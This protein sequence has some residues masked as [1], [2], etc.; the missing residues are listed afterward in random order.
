MD[1]AAT[2]DF[3]RAR[4]QA[5]GS[6]GLDVFMEAANACYYAGGES[7]G[8]AGDFITAPEISQ[9]FGE[10]IG[11]WTAVIWQSLGSPASF[12]LVELG[13]GR[14]T[15]MAD[16]LRAAAPMP[17]FAAA[18]RIHLVER[19]TGLMRRQK[20]ALSAHAV[21]WHSDLTSLPHGP[22]IVI[23]NE[24][25]D[26]LPIRQWEYAAHGW[27]ERRIAIDA[28]G[29]FQFILK[30][31]ELEVPPHVAATPGAIYETSPAVDAVTAALAAR[32][33]RDSGA[34]L[35]IDYGYGA[36][37]S[38]DTFQAV[39]KHAYA[40][41]LTAP[42]T[43]DLTAHVNFA[44]VATAAEAAGARVFGPVAQGAW[45]KRLG[46]DIRAERLARG[47]DPE[48]QEAVRAGVERLTD[49]R[50]MGS[51][52]KVMALASKSLAV[53]EGFDPAPSPPAPKEA[54]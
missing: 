52:F 14:G 43:R 32:I 38:G 11:L 3:L 27:T 5:E 31:C 48:T 23:A 44:A 8:A 25:L 26:A 29:A 17:G 4:I 40:E 33:G 49:A 18:A 42:G 21:Q 53:P 47:K 36:G 16:A 34:A 6:I 22:L 10:L 9:T 41:A 1:A 51:L 30:P 45:L 39:H 28:H 35:L 15:L 54:L 50:A 12:N 24:F 2:E 7:I 19:S 20:R 46:I 37:F 13:P